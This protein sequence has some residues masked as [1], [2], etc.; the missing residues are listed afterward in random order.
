MQIQVERPL[1]STWLQIPRELL[2]ICTRNC[3]YMGNHLV[4]KLLS[5]L[6]LSTDPDY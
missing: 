5:Y 6:L 1:S 4:Y 2:L 3:V